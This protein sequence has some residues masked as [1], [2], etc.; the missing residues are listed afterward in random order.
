[1]R[2][3]TRCSARPPSLSAAQRSPRERS[4]RRCERAHAAQLG[5]PLSAAQRSP[6]ELIAPPV[7]ASALRACAQ[8]ELLFVQTQHASVEI[9]VNAGDTLL[10]AAFVHTFLHSPLVPAPAERDE[11]ALALKVAEKRSRRSIMLDSASARDLASAAARTQPL[12]PVPVPVGALEAVWDD[13]EEHDDADRLVDGHAPAPAVSV[14]AGAKR[15]G[16]QTDDQPMPV[17]E[18]AAVGASAGADAGAVSN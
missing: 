1:M 4:S 5:P 8:V 14:D 15:T 9:D 17:R 12:L 7:R 13:A 11:V 6:R 18:R 2:E 10:P 3:G 16:G